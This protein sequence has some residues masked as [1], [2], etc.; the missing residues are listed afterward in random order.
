MDASFKI[1]I[2]PEKKVNPEEENK[3][4]KKGSKNPNNNTTSKKKKKEEE[5]V[6]IPEMVI[7]PFYCKQ[8]RITVKRNGFAHLTI[9]F[10]PT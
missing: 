2:T 9:H 1:E 4:K 7:P 3:A 5:E 6:K 8:D 10:M